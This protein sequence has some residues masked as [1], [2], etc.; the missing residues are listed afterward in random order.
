MNT[1]T[2]KD[3]S[4]VM[5]CN[6]ETIKK[7][8]RRLYPALME[9]GKTTYLDEEQVTNVKKS[10]ES[11]QHFDNLQRSLRVKTDLDLM[12]NAVDLISAMKSRVNELQV[13]VED[14]K[15]KAI[16][17]DQFIDNNS[18]MSWGDVAKVIGIGRNTLTK[19]MR[20][21]NIID[22][23]NI[24]YQQ[25]MKRDLFE[26]K[27][28]PNEHIEKNHSITLVTAKGLEFINGIIEDLK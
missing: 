18:L 10:I 25:Y 7:W 14:L 3:L 19:F 22:K 21:N 17:Y 12:Q 11:N 26:V 9:N 23:N 4:D 6:P 27:L 5:G 24:P 1:I 16:I 20:D 8:V 15:P 13:E 28:K 2:I